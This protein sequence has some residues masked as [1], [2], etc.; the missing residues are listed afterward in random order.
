MK[1]STLVVFL[2]V[3]LM[4]SG[5][6]SMNLRDMG[7]PF[8]PTST[9]TPLP[10]VPSTPTPTYP[11]KPAF[12]SGSLQTQILEND[13][14]LFTD[15]E[16]AHQVI[17]P[18]EW[19]VFVPGDP[20]EEQLTAA[21][22]SEVPDEFRSLLTAA[23]EQPGTRFVAVDYTYKYYFRTP[24]SITLVFATDKEALDLEM[25]DI[26]EKNIEAVPTL[27]PGSAVTYQNVQTNSNGLEYGKMIINQTDEGYNIPIK[28][29]IAL[30]KVPEG[31]LLMIGSTPEE[32]FSAFETPFQK[33][34]DSLKPTE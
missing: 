6:C 22:G 1:K 16:F 18:P 29:V 34:I 23:S 15:T 3:F 32:Y 27:M 5:G 13:S 31:L 4:F 26:L 12:P 17:L 25:V 21:F 28:R 14:T 9:N 2:L 33:V 20:L 7:I 24:A 19:L 11:P 8:V 10:P 30:F